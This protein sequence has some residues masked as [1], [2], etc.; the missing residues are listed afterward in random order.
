MA[1]VTTPPLPQAG[2]VTPQERLLTLDVLRGVALLGILLVNIHEF[3]YPELYASIVGIEVWNGSWDPNTLTRFFTLTFFSTKWAPIYSFLFGLGLQMMCSRFAAR[4]ISPVKTISRRLGVLF[5]FGLL[6]A[7]LFWYG[8]ILLMYSLLGFIVLLFHTLSARATLI[9]TGLLVLGMAGVYL[10]LGGLALLGEMIEPGSSTFDESDWLYQ[11]FE[12]SM[13]VYGQG[14][15]WDIFKHRW[16]DNLLCWGFSLLWAPVSLAWMFTGAWTVK[17]GFHTRLS[18]S[19]RFQK[20]VLISSFVT[21]PVSIY[22]ALDDLG[23]TSNIFIEYL[24][25]LPALIVVPPMISICYVSGIAL[26]VE[27]TRNAAAWAWIAAA[28]RMPLTNYLAQSAIATTL[29]YGGFGMESA[30]LKQEVDT[31]PVGEN[32]I[33]ENKTGGCSATATAH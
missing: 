13:Q 3:R 23:V 20:I 33:G 17:A 12:R 1:T 28:G 7:S 30:A 24:I 18:G 27:R 21:I 16:V 32:R 31:V 26:W 29:F 8:D 5:L 22:I 9:V 4:H 25:L 15:W 11:H 10:A 19:S 2:P 14:S 6:H